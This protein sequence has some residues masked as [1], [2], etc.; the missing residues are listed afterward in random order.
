MCFKPFRLKGDLKKHVKTVHQQEMEEHMV[1]IHEEGT[2]QEL[3]W[4]SMVAHERA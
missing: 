3:A 4:T 1:I 2:Q